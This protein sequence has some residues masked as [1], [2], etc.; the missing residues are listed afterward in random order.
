MKNTEKILYFAYGTNLNKKKFLKKYKN[1]RYLSKYILKD[2]ELVFR[3][4]YRV[5]DIQRKRGSNVKGIIYEID[6]VTEKKLDRYEDYPKLYIKKFFNKNSKRV[7]FYFMKRK[8]PTLKP[9]KYYLEVMKS[10]Y[11]QNNFKFNLKY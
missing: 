3:S 2:F 5:A 10:G 1:A 4:K 9:A 11:R 8:T 7:M 6:E